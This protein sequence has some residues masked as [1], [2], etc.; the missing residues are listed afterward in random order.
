MHLLPG[1]DPRGGLHL[2]VE[3]PAPGV[4]AVPGLRAADDGTGRD[5]APVEPPDDTADDTPRDTGATVSTPTGI[6]GL[7]P[8]FS[9]PAAPARDCPCG[10]GPRRH[11]PIAARYCRA[12]V[13]GGL[14]RACICPPA[15][16]T[17]VWGR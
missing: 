13:T 1:T 6:P 7:I 16:E 4:R 2:L 9:S 3:R 17:Q 10:H 8:E 11:D 12:T 14:R 15:A 5:V